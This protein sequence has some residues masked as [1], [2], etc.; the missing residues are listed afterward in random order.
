MKNTF[1]LLTLS[2]LSLNSM[3]GIDGV[4]GDDN[5]QDV[6][7]SK[8][9]LHKK[10]AKST[11][12]MIH[13]GYFAKTDKPNVFNIQGARTLEQGQNI[14]SSEK[15]SQQPAV[16]GCSGFLVSPN[17]IVT[18]GH[19]FASGGN[20]EAE[21]QNKVWVFDFAL[22]S[23]SSDPTRNIPIT[24]I[25]LCKKVV[26]VAFNA[27]QDFAIIKLDRP[28]FGRDSLKFRTSGKISSGSDL[29]TIGHPSGLPSKITNAGKVTDNSASD[30]FSTN[31]DTFH[32]NS[33]S[34]VFHSQS[35]LVEGILIQGKPD[36]VASIQSNPTSCKVVNTCDN[37]GKNCKKDY[38]DENNPTKKGEVV[39]RITNIVKDIEAAIK[40]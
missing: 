24:N 21:C 25:Y 33:G 28:V 22:E 37:T 40:L 31:L 11:A 6:Y 9:S 26:K 30:R 7:Q 27:N 13:G 1:A 36:Y 15:F 10:L 20:P 4:Y 18:A 14:C 29:V 2:L 3:A 23:N 5:R 38:P 32:G 8:S 35:G 39:Y 17:T 16:A 19:C 12:A 34:A